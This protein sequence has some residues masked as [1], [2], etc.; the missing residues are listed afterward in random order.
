[1][2][3]KWG[4]VLLG[5]IVCVMIALGIYFGVTETRHAS[6][7]AAQYRM[8]QQQQLAA[9]S[10]TRYPQYKSPSPSIAMDD[11]DADAGLLMEGVLGIKN[12]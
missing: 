2:H 4:Y 11:D 5:L 10:R 6:P 3:P 12:G 9:A 8:G 1:M 7:E